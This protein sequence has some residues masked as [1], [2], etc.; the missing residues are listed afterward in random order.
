MESGASSVTVGP[1]SLVVKRRRWLVVATVTLAAALAAWLA[2][3]AWIA[4][5]V[6][7][8][9]SPAGLG[10]GL[11]VLAGLNA[12]CLVAFLAGRPRWRHGTALLAGVEVGNVVF[13]VAAAV[14]ISSAWLLE[15]GV[16][17]ITAVLVVL[18]DRSRRASLPS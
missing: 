17:G 13:F 16:A 1:E 6:C 9:L 10:L 14:A 8:W 18:V 2:V 4:T 7:C 15:A 5:S 11:G 12:I 3:G